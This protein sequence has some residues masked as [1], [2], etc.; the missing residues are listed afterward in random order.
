MAPLLSRFWSEATGGSAVQ[1]VTKATRRAAA[2][3]SHTSCLLGLQ[4][5]F[6]MRRLTSD[7]LMCS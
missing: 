7:E 2:R 5:A 6:G 1:P 4:P 3:A